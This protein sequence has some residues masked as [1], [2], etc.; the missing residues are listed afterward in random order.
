MDLGKDLFQSNRTRMSNNMGKRLYQ[1]AD[2]YGQTLAVED[3]IHF[4]LWL[5]G[6]FKSYT[7]ESQTYQQTRGLPAFYHY[8]GKSYDPLVDPPYASD[9]E[10]YGKDT[11]GAMKAHT[12]NGNTIQADCTSSPFLRASGFKRP[13]NVNSKE[14]LGWTAEKSENNLMKQLG[15]SAMMEGKKM[16]AGDQRGS[17][18]FTYDKLPKTMGGQGKAPWIGLDSTWGKNIPGKRPENL[19]GLSSS[20][21]ALHSPLALLQARCL[22]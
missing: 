13:C 11:K 22:V 3:M 4:R 8:F 21:I 1:T 7:L 6:F 2:L 14:A 19:P 5:S 17:V 12:P 10:L 15:R 9:Y 20:A 16:N 18:Y